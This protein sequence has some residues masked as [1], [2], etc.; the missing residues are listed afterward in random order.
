[1]AEK[2]HEEHG[3]GG[4][5][6]HGGGAAHGGGGGHEEH[7]GA[8]EWLIS[9]ADNVALMMGFFVILLAMNMKEPTAG[10]IGG[11]E[12]NGGAPSSSRMMEL[13]LGIR[14]AFHSELDPS[15]P[16]D[17]ELNRY[18]KR[19]T[20][21]GQS[22]QP[23]ETGPGREHQTVIPTERSSLGG[24][25]PFEDDSETLSASGKRRAEEIGLK[26]RGMRF[27]IEVRGHSSP[28]E[29]GRNWVKGEA[30][31]HA[32][33]LAVAKALAEQGVLP[34]QMRI[35][36]C[37]D[38]ERNIARDYDRDNDRMNQRVEV[39]VTNDQMPDETGNRPGLPTAGPPQA[40][41]GSASGGEH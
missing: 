17:A 29:T 39:I 28:S 10:G 4:G 2:E 7:E 32:R 18:K 25:V 22:Q 37:G 20:E 6:G 3:S 11:R 16:N 8:P 38:N 41:A 9:F 30:L 31:S 15:D 36:A 12:K 33:A 24:V 34:T 23:H 35:A 13:A 27:I 40:G 19:K 1:V 26:L 14:E 5:G 21:G